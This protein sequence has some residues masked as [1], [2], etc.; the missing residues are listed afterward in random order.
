MSFLTCPLHFS[1]QGGNP[2]G[3]K[4]C[5]KLDEKLKFMR[6]PEGGT[7]SINDRRGRSLESLNRYN[8]NQNLIA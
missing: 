6:S 3:W 2:M 7:R 1:T 5:N 4:E 8:M